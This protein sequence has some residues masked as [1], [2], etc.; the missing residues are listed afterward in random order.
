MDGGK[1]EVKVQNKFSS[2]ISICWQWR[3][4]NNFGN[5]VMKSA[6]LIMLNEIEKHKRKEI[7]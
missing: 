1:S 4:M 3:A 2:R 7:L 6:Y 5:I